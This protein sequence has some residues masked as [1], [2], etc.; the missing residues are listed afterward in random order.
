M[1]G[2]ILA[3]VVLYVLQTFSAPTAQY[4]AGNLTAA[5]AMGPR[6][7]PVPLSPVA[8][9]LNRAAANMVEAL[10]VFIPIAV[11]LEAKGMNTGLGLAGVQVFFWARLAYVPAY[12]AAI[13]PLRSIVWTV[14]HAGLVMMGWALWQGA[15]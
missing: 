10:L 3:V 2:W 1:T 4:L 5:H 15:G 12:A 7:T 9:R 6:D 13:G 8:G 11:L 14:G